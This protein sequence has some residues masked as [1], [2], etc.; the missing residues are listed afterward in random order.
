[1]EASGSISSTNSYLT[2]IRMFHK[3][4]KCKKI[5]LKKLKRSHIEDIILSD[6]VNLLK[7]ATRVQRLILLRVYLRWLYEHGKTRFPGDELIF[8]TDFPKIPQYLPRPHWALLL[9]R[10][11]GIRIGELVAITYDCVRYD[12]NKPFL[13]VELGK[14]KNERLVPLDTKTLWL[15]KKIQKRSL[16]TY[17]SIC[18]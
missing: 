13:K 3:F 18:T 17:R 8:L 2:T 5:G 9:M 4:L 14:L 15:I 6:W 11:T 16:A 7:P 12:D 10:W 1:M